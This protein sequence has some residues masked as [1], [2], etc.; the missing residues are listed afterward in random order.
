M[1]ATKV[2][3]TCPGCGAKYRIPDSISAKKVRCKKCGSAIFLRLHGAFRHRDSGTRRR[4]TGRY[5]RLKGA[6][7]VKMSPLHYVTAVVTLVLLVA[8]VKVLLF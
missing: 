5:A 4:P 8:I 6:K 1:E 2:S 7:P 3:I